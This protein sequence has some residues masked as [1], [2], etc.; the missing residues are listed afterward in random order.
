[1]LLVITT[2]IICPA[3]LAAPFAEGP[4]L[5][6]VN[7]FDVLVQLS[8]CQSKRTLNLDFSIEKYN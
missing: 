1:M 6:I 5:G 7:S 4:I 2:Q 3:E 8:E